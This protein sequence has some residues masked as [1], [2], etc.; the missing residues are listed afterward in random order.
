MPTRYYKEFAITGVANEESADV[1]IQSTEAEKKKI[2]GMILHVT[3]QIGNIIKAYI[4]REKIVGL[5][6]YHLSTDE[7]TGSAN[8]QKDNHRMQ[9]I[10]IDHDLEVGRTFNMAISCG[11]TAKNLFGSYVYEL[12]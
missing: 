1:G 5:Y 12:L 3:G 10:A 4:E 6:D 2:V 11:A 7:S 8:V 9:F